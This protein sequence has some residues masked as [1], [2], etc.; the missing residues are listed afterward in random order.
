MPLENANST[1]GLYLNLK[2]TSPSTNSPYRF[3]DVVRGGS[4][5]K[6][7]WACAWWVSH[8]V[9]EGAWIMNVA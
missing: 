1:R 9:R 2:L 8:I 5:I 3:Q 7:W 4:N 6:M